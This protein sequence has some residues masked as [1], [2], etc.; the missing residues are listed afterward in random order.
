MG[1]SQAEICN[2]TSIHKAMFNFK[3]I[4]GRGGF[5][6]V[7][8]VELKRSKTT[9]A[10]KEMQKLKIVS[11][12]SVYSVMNEMK[13]LS[14]FQHPF[15][16][17]MQYAF[18]DKSNLYLAMDL[19]PGGDLRYHFG[20]MKRF[21]EQQ[22]KFFT[23]CIMSGLEYLH[24]HGIIH[25]D[26]KPENI[27]LDE[28]GYAHITDF[29][30]AGIIN[31][32]NYK[33]TSG[34]PGYMAPE[35]LCR[36]SHGIAADYFA[37]GVMI[38]EFMMGKRPYDGKNRKEIKERVLARQVQLKKSDIPAGWSLE[39]ADFV[40]KL[41][42][43]KPENRLG[44]NGPQDVKNHVWLRDFPWPSLYDKTMASPY[45]PAKSD[46][47]SPNVELDFPGDDDSEVS[48]KLDTV[49]EMFKGYHYECKKQNSKSESTLSSQ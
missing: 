17:N 1:N 40:N 8:K 15:I 9:Y 19:M 47:F 18:Q 49:Q 38:Y 39:A 30:I 4:I 31:P 36:K 41:I 10:M 16:V 35:V 26:I 34:T 7:W 3:Y 44:N 43:R 45:L 48:L 24:V 37:L 33:D 2:D 25:R 42:Q 13:L 21:D 20:R 6:K 23:A 46:N 29:G 27:V 12:K 14:K 28:S 5:G 11:K 22:T 32:K